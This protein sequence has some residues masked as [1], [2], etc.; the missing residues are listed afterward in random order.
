[1]WNAIF[2]GESFTDE[3]KWSPVKTLTDRLSIHAFEYKISGT[4]TLD[5]E[6]YTSISGEVW[7]SNGV[8]ATGVGSASGPETNGS[9]I[10]PLRLKPGDLIKFKAT[11]TGTLTLSGWFTQK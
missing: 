9:D 8:K 4:G 5:I 2:E 7:I 11:A 3:T 6:V 10:V 1:M